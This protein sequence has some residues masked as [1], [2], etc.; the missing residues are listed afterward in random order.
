MEEPETPKTNS[1]QS[2]IP[3]NPDCITDD[4]W[5][6]IVDDLRFVG[7]RLKL[8]AMLRSTKSLEFSDGTITIGYPSQSNVERMQSE[9]ELPDSRRKLSEVLTK[10]LGKDCRIKVI[11][12]Q[13]SP[14]GTQGI[15]QRS[16]LAQGAISMGAKV[17]STREMEQS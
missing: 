4:Q 14:L 8:G 5:K 16:H 1:A 10:V 3:S 9:M 2:E 7:T 13:K 17:M 6:R 12:S 11:L 15:I